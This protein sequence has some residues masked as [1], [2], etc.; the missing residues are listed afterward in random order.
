M[1][2]HKILEVAIA[3]RCEQD[4]GLQGSLGLMEP[5]WLSVGHS[6]QGPSELQ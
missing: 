6:E 5:A 3:L 4:V 2:T 1:Y